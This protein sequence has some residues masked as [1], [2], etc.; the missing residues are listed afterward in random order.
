[1]TVALICVII[2]RATENREM[3]EIM[4]IVLD[5]EF[6]TELIKSYFCSDLYAVKLFLLPFV[7][8]IKAHISVAEKTD[9]SSIMPTLIS[10]HIPIPTPP[11]MKAHDGLLHSGK[12]RSA[13]SLLISPI[14]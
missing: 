3:K 4:P 10:A 8:V 14:E 13:S 1:M 9:A 5:P 12:R 7:R 6:F 2:P 11:T